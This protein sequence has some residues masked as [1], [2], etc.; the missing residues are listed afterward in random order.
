MKSIFKLL[1]IIT[2][3]IFHSPFAYGN[4]C[5][6][7]GWDCDGENPPAPGEGSGTQKVPLDEY[8]GLLLATGV[9]AAGV[10]YYNKEKQII[11]K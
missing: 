2:V 6:G 9:L 1:T 3:L 5:P 4:D 10:I 8:A 11:K 7:N